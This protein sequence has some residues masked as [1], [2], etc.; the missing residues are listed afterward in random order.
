MLP[1][2]HRLSVNAEKRRRDWD[3]RDITLTKD[4]DW[5][6][7][8]QRHETYALLVRAIQDR[9]LS[10]ELAMAT[11]LRMRC[12]KARTVLATAM[13]VR[14][15]DVYKQVVG[16]PLSFEPQG[17]GKLIGGEYKSRLSL[18][19]LRR[20]LESYRKVWKD[21]PTSRDLDDD[22]SPQ[23]RSLLVEHAEVFRP[24]VDAMRAAGYTSAEHTTYQIRYR[25]QH[26]RHVAA[27]AWHMDDQTFQT[28][29]DDGTMERAWNESDTRALVAS[30]CVNMEP[31][32]GDPTL[33]TNCG[34]K[35]AVGIPVLKPEALQ[36]ILRAT[37]KVA[38]EMGTC[39]DAT[40]V[41][42]RLTRDMFYATEH[43]V[44]WFQ[45]EVGTLRSAGV[46]TLTL[47]N[48]VIS[49]YNDFMFHQANKDIPPG[50]SRVF[51]VISGNAQGR[52]G[53]DI[54]FR[55]DAVLLPNGGASGEEVSLMFQSV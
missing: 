5:Y 42:K 43:A 37:L 12:V 20:M 44:E 33:W 23:I 24:M 17:K 30:A 14:A 38:V 53:E 54:P 16:D 22:V 10:K 46:T 29:A 11:L 6:E 45:K 2:L 41:H 18:N 21:D 7:A 48:G 9:M 36:R 55:S 1:S 52:T 25:F 32:P 28:Y 50:Y 26:I 13:E 4:A 35:L 34:T 19:G 31:N 51:F 15:M 8:K 27:A 39:T 47:E 3:A 49:D 40:L